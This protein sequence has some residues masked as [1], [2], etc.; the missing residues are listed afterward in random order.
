MLKPNK[1]SSDFYKSQS[2]QDIETKQNNLKN[3]QLNLNHF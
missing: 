1:V 2:K 3:H